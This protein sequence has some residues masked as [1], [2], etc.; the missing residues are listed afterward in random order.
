MKKITARK[1]H[2]LW[3]LSEKSGY[4]LMCPSAH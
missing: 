1:F 4:H 3:L 2:R